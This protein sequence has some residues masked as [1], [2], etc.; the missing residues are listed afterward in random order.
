MRKFEIIPPALCF[1]NNRLSGSSVKTDSRQL[2]DLSGLF[3][4]KASFERLPADTPVYDVYSHL[5]VAEGVAGGLYFG[6]TQIYPGQ[7]G[8]EYFMTKGHYHQ[9]TDR[10]EY[11]WG[12]AGEGLLILMDEQRNTWAER[13]YPGS[14]HYIPGGVAHRVAN[15]TERM[16]SFAACWPSDAG[17]NYHAIATDGFSARLLEVD[18]IPQLV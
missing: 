4:D 14:I 16:L 3:K 10:A 7:V 8:Q 17:H 13:M 6:L 15:C 18:G 1:A 12:I 11:Y 2:G 9:Q 5:P